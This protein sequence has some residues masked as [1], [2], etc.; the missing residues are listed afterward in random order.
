MKCGAEIFSRLNEY[1]K[2]AILKV[3]TCSDYVLIKGMPGT[4]KTQTLV[5][6]IELLVKLNLSVLITAHTNTAVDN[7]LVK[8]LDRNVDFVRF[9]SSSRIHSAVS[10]KSDDCVTAN[11]DSPES[12]HAVYCSKVR[13]DFVTFRIL[14][15]FV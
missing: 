3:F 15:I 7:I 9:G 8:L 5:A 10:H 6:L 11:C 1:Q 4:G 14:N 13:F 12:L 2:Q